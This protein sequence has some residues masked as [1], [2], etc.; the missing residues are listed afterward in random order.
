MQVLADNNESASAGASLSAIF[1]TATA[2]VY[3]CGQIIGEFNSSRSAMAVM[4]EKLKNETEQRS[5]DQKM[6]VEKLKHADEKLKNETEQRSK[7]QQITDEKLKNEKEQRS[8]EQQITDEKLKLADE[9]L[10]N[11]KQR[12]KESYKNAGQRLNKGYLW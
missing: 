3:F 10:K 8:K 4:A 7:D 6:M 12:L 2:G 11:A 1:L 9:K 5:K